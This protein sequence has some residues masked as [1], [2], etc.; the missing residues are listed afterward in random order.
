MIRRVDQ[1]FWDWRIL[2]SKN[3]VQKRIFTMPFIFLFSLV[4]LT[5]LLFCSNQIVF[6]VA[7]IESFAPYRL[8][9]LNCIFMYKKMLS[10]TKLAILIFGH[11]FLKS[12][13]SNT[14]FSINQQLFLLFFGI[15]VVSRLVLLHAAISSIYAVLLLRLGCVYAAIKMHKILL[16]GILHAPLSYFDQTPTGRILSRFSHDTEVVDNEFPLLLDELLY[17]AFEVNFP[18]TQNKK[19]IRKH[20]TKIHDFANI[21][22]CSCTQRQ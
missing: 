3:R 6:C 18:W 19:Y 1:L 9:T 20:V 17:C 22:N 12:I 8:I 13:W 16:A 11:F 15:F 2:I 14:V 10:L 5:P 7:L 4:F 21:L